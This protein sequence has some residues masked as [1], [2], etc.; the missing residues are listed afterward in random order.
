MSYGQ[1]CPVAKAAD[2]LSERWML[3]VVRELC[4]GSCR[5][6]E[7]QKGLSRIS[8]SLLTKR[9]KELEH[10]GIIVRK[11]EKNRKGY[12]YYL[13]PA[14]KELQP[15]IEQLATWGM[16]W[17]RGHLTDDELDVEFLMWDL[18]R[19]IKLDKLPS[20]ETVFCF[21]FTDIERYSDWWV[22]IENSSIDLC[23]ENIGKEVDLYIRSD[24][25]TMV[26]VWDG[27][28]CIQKALREGRI[29]VQG[30][31]QLAKTMADWLGISPFSKIR[32]GDTKMTQ[33][34]ERQWLDKNS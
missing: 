19:R 33:V 7:L 22:V 10:A 14:G 13:T 17:T 6:G 16:R 28:L 27:A 25:R 15:L 3:L 18:Q 2:I 21:I 31:K 8:P 29:H 26:D 23:T 30:E 5:F 9:L 32:P 20:G 11:A 24:I 34:T 1:F 4:L 12:S